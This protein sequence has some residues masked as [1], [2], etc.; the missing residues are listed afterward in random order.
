MKKVLIFVLFLFVFSCVVNG[1]SRME[2]VGIKILVPDLK[3]AKDFYLGVLKFEVE[4][5][6]TDAKLVVLKTGGYKI[7]LNESKE[8]KT[9]TETGY[10]HVSIALRVNDL[11]KTIE[12]LKANNV[13]LIKDE[14][15]KEG[16]GYSIQALDPFGNKIS[17]MEITVGEKKEVKEPQ[18]YN[19]GLYVSDI[20]T[21]LS[22]YRDQLGFVE[23]TQRY[24][25]DDMP[26]LYEDKKFAF[27]LHQRRTDMPFID[28]PNMRLVFK[29]AAGESAD[30]MEKAGIKLKKIFGNMHQMTDSVGIVSEVLVGK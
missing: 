6:S 20:K 26:L 22:T 15:R 10:S 5:E 29:L 28:T 24:M 2:L 1:A 3:K 16:V 23:M 18:I 9:I 19:C 7:M 17:L 13:R 4:Q 8:A 11:D 30:T 25:P 21:A 12:H 27:M 14:K